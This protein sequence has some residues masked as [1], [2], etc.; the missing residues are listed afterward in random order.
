MNV[1]VFP[2]QG[3]QKIGMGQNLYENFQ[4]AR[5]VFDEVDDALNFKLSS[6]MFEGELSDLSLTSNAQPALMTCSIAVL[7]VLEKCI[8]KKFFEICDFVCGHSLGEF[9]ALC[10]S[11]VI[12]LENTAKLLKIRGDAMQK[13]VPAGEGAMAALLSSNFN[14]LDQL[15]IEV[16]NLGVCQVANDN[17]NEQVVISG[18]FK[19]VHEAVRIASKFS[20]RKSILLNVSAPFHCELMQPAQDILKSELENKNF[21]NPTVPIICNYNAKCEESPEFLK[22][23]IIKQVTSK[24]RWRE[25]MNFVIEKNVK[26]II[27]LGS[28]KVLTG[29][30]KRFSSEIDCY[31]LETK[32]DLENNLFKFN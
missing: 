20:I 4:E 11:G 25:T 29:I 23:N 2:G 3:S 28:G 18:S 12:S 10:A 15:L 8:S 32:V 17:S 13:A 26:Q 24:V 31:N 9:T 21:S 30:A 6:L 19:A 16:K 5:D 1:I 14:Q 7:R 22:N 27:E